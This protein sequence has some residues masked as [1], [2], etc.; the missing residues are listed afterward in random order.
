MKYKSNTVKFKNK[1]GHLLA[2]KLE[3][4]KAKIKAYLVFAH[5]FTC[6]KDIFAATRIARFLAEK[7]FATLRFDF[8]GIGHSEGDF[9]DSNFT[10]NIADLHAAVDFLRAEYQAPLGLIG[11]SLG[12]AAALAVAGH[13]P[14]C[15]LVS[16]IGSP[17][18]PY[19]VASHFEDYLQEI[20]N[21]GEACIDIV[22]KCLNITKQFIDDVKAKKIEN[23]IKNLKKEVLIF[24]SPLD[25]VVG[26]DHASQ[27]FMWAKHP[28]SFISLDQADHLITKA[29]DAAFIADVI[30]DVL[31]R[32]LAP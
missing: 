30:G 22:G 12:G 6:S 11:H 16:T 26:I 13:V 25:D 31:K 5:C 24:H 3:T 17:S 32:A 9:E 7:G 19:H 20:E 18:D 1:A 4:P 10:T 8:R 21:E 15:K 23:C 27:I 28:K 29:E 2:G 14:E